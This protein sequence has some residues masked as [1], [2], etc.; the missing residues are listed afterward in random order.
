[1]GRR[2]AYLALAIALCTGL[3]ACYD[4]P[5][6]VCGF[7]CGTGGACPD[8]YTCN[9]ADNVCHL[10]GSAPMKCTGAPDGGIDTPDSIG[11]D[12]GGNTP[13]SVVSTNPADGA[14]GVAVTSTVTATFSEEV[15]G[16]NASTFSLSQGA[17]TVAATVSYASSANPVATLTPTAQLLPNTTYTA[18]L[19][20]SIVD[21]GN[22]ALPQK[23]WTF[24]TA[25]DTTAPTVTNRTPAPNAT[26]VALSSTVTAQFSEN[27]TGVSA[28]TFTLADGASAIAGTVTF[29]T[30]NRTATFTPSAALP[31]GK[32]LTATLTSGIADGAGNALS[33]APVSWTFTTV[34]DT[35]APT[36]TIRVPGPGATMVS[37]STNI[38]VT[39]DEPV[40]NVTAASFTVND[41]AAVTGALASAMGGREWTFTPSA[42]LGTNATVTVTLTTAIT[43]VSG[44]ALAAP[45]T[46][47]FMTAPDTTAPTVTMR[48]PAPNATMVALDTT[49]VATFSEPVMGVTTSTF[50][51]N[52]GSAIAGTVASSMGGRVWTFTPSAALPNSSVVTAT[53]GTGIADLA[54]N[55]LAAPVT[56]M[57]TT[58]PDTT[59]PTVTT[60]SPAP[61]ATMVSS[62]S[63][64][65]VTFSEP[66]TN[67]TSSSFTVNNGAAVTGTLAG[68]NGN[69]TWTFTPLTTLG[70]NATVT[71]TL[72]TAITDVAGNPL[73]AAVTWMFT[74]IPDTTPPTV[75]S[76]FP[77]TNGTLVPTNSN[78]TVNFSEPVTGVTTASFTV[79]DGSAV[80]GVLGVSNG[81]A[82]W[83]FVPTGTMAAAVVVT[84]TLTT[85]ITDM[86]GNPLAASYSYN[87]STAGAGNGSRPSAQSS[88]P[89]DGATGVSTGTTIAVMFSEP[90][91]GV[92]ATSFTVDAGGT[93]AGTRASSDGGRTWTFTPSAALPSGTLVTVMVTS[94]VTDLEGMTIAPVTYTFTTQ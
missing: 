63:T 31:A 9:S 71:V 60:R 38:V 48:T 80:A 35:T 55:A 42:A 79:N 17:Q 34:A 1:M 11:V 14:S 47:M 16:V 4:V 68:S 77:L 57:F 86:A 18:T 61:N 12:M 28:T 75:A 27:V 82:T 85:A 67:V 49:I 25:A 74:T 2:I 59:A 50:T 78:I 58:V 44:N 92:D 3:V 15:F 43:D 23:T 7:V 6:P 56:W 24:T 73:A 8:D 46:W 40:M 10:N 87:F 33:G 72:T 62:T 53:L 13:P 65:A 83:T 37:P 93:I 90:V 20:S 39:F 81:G 21:A 64:I 89:A 94:A 45:V 69:R 76:T 19:M 51:A 29:T 41:G 84:V 26:G 30:G 5:Q 52:N 88:V 70:S 54:G 36:V 22:A 66:V 32:T 91:I